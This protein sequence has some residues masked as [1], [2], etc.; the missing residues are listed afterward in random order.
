VSE[1]LQETKEMG[2]SATYEMSLAFAAAGFRDTDL[3]PRVYTLAALS[4]RLK[5]VRVG[6]KDGSYLI[7]GG[8][9]SI[10]KRADENLQSAELIILDGDSSIDPE[11]GE[12]L[13]GAPSFHAVHDA[14]KDMNIAHIMHTS[15]S[16]RGS[17]G[18]V[19]FWKYRI[20]I[21]CKMQSQ[22]ELTAAVDYFIAE[23]HKRQIWMNCVNENYRWS[24]PW[25]LPRVSKDE[26]KERF[27]HRDHLDGKIFSI[28]TAISWQR[29]TE[30]QNQ[31][32][33]QIK[34][35]PVALPTQNSTTISQFNE[36]HGL[37]WMRAQ[38]ASMGY[39]FS[40]YDKRNDAYRYLAPTSETGTPG[41]MLFKGSRGDWVTYSHHGAHDPLSQKVVD[42][43]ALYAIA[44]FSGDNSAAIRS[45][46]P[47]EKSIT[48]QLSEIRSH[49]LDTVAATQQSVSGNADTPSPAPKKRIEI[50]RMDELKDEAVQWLIEDLVPAKAFAAIY[51]KPGSFKSFVAIY[52]S[53]MIAAGQPAFGKPTAQGTCLYIAGEGQAGLK[54]RSDAS[55]ITHEIEPSVPLYFIKRSLNL[56][57]TLEDMQELIKEIRELGI[58]PSLIVIDTLAR[59]FVGDENSSSDMSQFI[60]VIGE[61]IAQLSC[62]VLVV[63]HAGKDESKGMRGSSALLGAVDAELEC[64]RTSDE[65]DREHL[66]G[67]LTT[68]KQ[69]ESEDGIEFHFEMVKVLTDPV[70]PNIVS[71]GLRPSEKQHSKRKQKKQL[72]ESEIFTLEAFDLAVAEVGKRYGMPGIPVDKLCIRRADWLAYFR[73]LCAGDDKFSERTYQ[74]AAASL[75]VAKIIA[76]KGDILWKTE[77]HQHVTE[78]PDKPTLPDMA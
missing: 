75:S 4:D 47:R 15:H 23:L 29:Q 61:L 71:L 25:F 21:P 41:V 62:S 66:T 24:Q 20:L 63:H 26:E 11:T 17:D 31:I 2:N 48:E 40:H 53:Q 54:K 78:K 7:R 10:C 45:I 35:T 33:D 56:S 51:G 70:D 34:H 22:E 9:L 77:Q 37:E 13:T 16:N 60:S 18:V 68:T 1:T 39:R 64:V 14:L 58:A 57:S 65:E 28:D 52:L 6:P 67:K 27:V 49:Q 59:N 72:T 32:I 5:H 42:P 55:R 44:N 19:S 74:R 43:F 38:L 46:Q 50:L 3:K 76:A 36:Q 12:I 8:N 30:Q 69:K 73:H